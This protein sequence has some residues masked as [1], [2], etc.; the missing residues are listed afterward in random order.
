MGILLKKKVSIILPSFNSSSTIER[1]IESILN[2][3]MSKDNLEI[4]VVDDCSSDGTWQILENYSDRHPDL[5]KISRLNSPSGSPAQPRNEGIELASGEYILFLDSDDWL[6]DEALSRM[7]VH[8]EEWK[9]DVLLIKLKGENGRDVPKS[10]FFENQSYV[11]VF[12]SKVMWSFSPLKLFRKELIDRLD[13]RFPDFMPEDISFVMRAYYFA[14]TVSVA[15]DYDYY[16]VSY[17][18]PEAHLSSST[19]SNPEA[20]LAALTDIFQ[21]LGQMNVTS[22]QANA[23]FMRRI[24]RRDVFN[25]LVYSAKITHSD[26]ERYFSRI[27][28]MTKRY[29]RR[30]MYETCPLKIRILLDIAYRKNYAAFCGAYGFGDALL[31]CCSWKRAGNTVYCYL[32]RSICKLRIDVGKTNDKILLGQLLKKSQD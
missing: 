5:I 20:N 29:Y 28:K 8:A 16:H 11:D 6:A 2:Q 21:T 14:D 9:S 26:G 23:T 7:V 17:D 32:P 10:M 4:I 30:D 18:D 27:I 25:M 31:D 15:A 13:L 3:T 19:W 1:A 24:F 12:K 22:E